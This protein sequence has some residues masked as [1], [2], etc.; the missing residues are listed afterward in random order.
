[1][2]ITGRAWRKLAMAVAVPGIALGTLAGFTAAPAM[3][4]VAQPNMPVPIETFH[5]YG[6]GLPN[7]DVPIYAH[8][9]FSDHGY[10]SLGNLG[11]NYT[12]YLHQGDIYV[13][14]WGPSSTPAVAPQSCNVS[15]TQNFGYHIY[16]GSGS[17][18]SLHGW[19]HGRLRI[20]AVVYRHNGTCQINDPV[21]GT[22]RIL[23][24]ASGRVWF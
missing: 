18:S 8:G 24:D 3:A 12:M 20:S 7:G 5:A 9:A 11:S 15:Y 16:N 19:G 13:H 14:T 4:S 21:P 2:A 22:F 17:Y 1:M 23:I 10:I 6:T